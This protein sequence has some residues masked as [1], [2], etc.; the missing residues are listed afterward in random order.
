ML[1]ERPLQVSMFAGYERALTG[2]VPV[3]AT[4]EVWGEPT[5][6]VPRED[7]LQKLQQKVA[8]R[9]NQ[10]LTGDPEPGAYR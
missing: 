10:G 5:G 6:K 4:E 2:K 8:R 9:P 3:E 7:A 1:P